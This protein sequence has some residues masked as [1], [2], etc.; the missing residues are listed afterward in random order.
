MNN[1]DMPSDDL[2]QFIL[3]ELDDARQ[4][5][6][7]KAIAEDAELASVAQWLATA[8]AAVRAENVGEVS[9]EFNDHLRRRLLKVFHGVQ[10]NTTR[11]T[12]LTRSLDTW[13]WIMRSRVSRVAAAAV[14]V[15]AIQESPCGST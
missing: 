14:F 15:L 3:G 4:P 10:A 9:D 13:R 2:L 7:R 8:V 11:P 6:V 1:N 12:I 5:A